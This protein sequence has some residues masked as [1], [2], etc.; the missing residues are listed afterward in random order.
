MILVTGASGQ[1]ASR[2]VT[3]LRTAGAEVAEGSRRPTAGGRVMDFD[4]PAT[5]DL[6]GVDTLVLVS[7]GYAED[8]VVIRRH[9]A[10][11]EAAGRDGV[12]HVV[13]TSLVG[14]GDHLGFAL[15]HRATEEHLRKSGLGR[16]V[17]RNGLYAELVGALLSWDGGV[18]ESP[19]AQG[20]VAASTRDDLARATARVAV[21]PTRHDAI[22]Y[23][24]TG[25][26]FTVEDVARH[27]EAPVNELPLGVYRERLL[28][29]SGLLPFQAPMLASIA[30]SIRHG[31]L[32][33]HGPDLAGLLG[34]DPVSGVES[35]AE[36]A[37]AV[38]HAGA[39][40]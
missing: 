3:H 14:A 36:S 5:I 25:S 35:A 38:R 29:A 15:A 34:R 16:T 27:L 10:V 11:L 30:T 7:A 17:M 26:P 8:D 24:L 21:D 32:A 6:D 39:S 37:L 33:E 31:F 20:P 22:T 2:I 12:E 28:A 40:S 19:F 18:L 1:L 13:Y 23:E 9:A 4:A